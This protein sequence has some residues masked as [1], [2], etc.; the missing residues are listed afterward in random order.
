MPATF[1]YLGMF[2]LANILIING[3]AHMNWKEKLY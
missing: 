1:E 2:K 3:N